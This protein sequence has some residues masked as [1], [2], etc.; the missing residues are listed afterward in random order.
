MADPETEYGVTWDNDGFTDILRS[1]FFD[2]NPHIDHTIEEYVE[3]ILFALT[4]AI[5]EHF[6][7]L[8]WRISTNPELEV[9][10]RARTT[11]DVSSSD[12]APYLEGKRS[13]RERLG[14]NS[15]GQHLHENQYRK[16]Q[17]TSNYDPS[18]N[19]M[20]DER[21]LMSSI[22]YLSLEL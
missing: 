4:E 17:R 8:E 20:T 10:K 1:T 21:Q 16:R 11:I 13:V 14:S 9:V 6:E 7:G 12:Y 19:H 15:D 3:C 18:N 22:L 5:N 2:V